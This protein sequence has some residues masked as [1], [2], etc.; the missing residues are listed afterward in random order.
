MSKDEKKEEQKSSALS[1]RNFLGM[2]AGTAAAFTIV[3]RHVLGG[4][5]YQAPSEMINVAG[6][7]VGA[8]G[9]G[10]IQRISDPD[11]P[12]QRPQRTQT[13]QPFTP[14]QIAEQ[15][16]QQAARM[17]AMQQQ[18]GQQRQQPPQGFQM[19]EREPVHL[20]N[21]Y[22]LCDV[23]SQYAGYIFAGY[24]KAKIYTDY[25]RM[26]D[27]EK[28]IDAIVIGTPDHNHAHIAAY[29]MKMGKHVY[30]EKPLCKT[31][32]EARKLAEI[33]KEMDVV[34]QMGNQGHASEDA[35]LINEWIAD[36]AIGLVR[37]VWCWTNRPTW[38]QGDIPRPAGVPVPGHIDWDLWLGPAPE[39][40]Y[41]PDICHFVWRGLRDYGT[42]ALGDMG[43]HIFD[44]PFWAL[45]LGLPEK[46]Q[47]SSTPYNDEYWPQGEIIT[48]EFSARGYM[49]P[50]K[51]TWVDGGL[52]A[53]RPPELE[54]GRRLPTSGAL[55]FG[56]K[57][58]LMHSDYGGSPRLIPETAM[59]AYERPD[60][61]MER[62]PGIHAEWIEA[63]KN[64]KKSSTDFSYSSRLV[65]TMMLG[66][67]AVLMANRN[68]T[69]E[70]DAVNMKF[71]N[72]PEADDLLHYEYRKGWAL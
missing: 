41:N 56:D 50:V 15:E 23:D 72:L 53:P 54:D 47:A 45:N 30:C 27:N 66:N 3:P 34:T 36:G 2:T 63:I 10:D 22:A 12:I 38:P 25:R 49:P 58:V 48:Y 19:P 7:G 8:Q 67:V 31:I 70:Y 21:I 5:G 68:T 62:S 51:L 57:G 61:W 52:T 35:R 20:A 6:I 33:A 24:P 1:R 4:A 9:G 39:K 64:G 69:L 65:E 11:V 14:E 42:G 59:E 18:G 32:Y 43:A 29:A 40:A 16:A 71:T 44:H 13:G 60:P 46:I 28:E 26:L 37:E 55:Y 17:A